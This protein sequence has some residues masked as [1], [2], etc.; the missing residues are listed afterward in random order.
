MSKSPDEATQS[1]IA[2]LAAK[3]GKSLAEWVKIVRKRLPAKH[4]EIV[5]FLKT[6]HE[7]GHGYANLVAHKALE[8]DAVSVAESGEDLVGSQYAGAKSALRP[9]YDRIIELVSALATMS[10]SH[11]R[12]PMSACAARN[13]LPSSSHP[14]R[15]ASMSASI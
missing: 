6:E 9:I 15:R 13:N 10:R 1:M 2:N 12:R 8:S 14:P 3:T 5:S 7:L 4:G 11:P